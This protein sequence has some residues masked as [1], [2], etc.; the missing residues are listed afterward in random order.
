MI[1]VEQL[2]R[3]KVTE[4]P[5]NMPGGGVR[6][7]L[8]IAVGVLIVA[9]ASVAWV[10]LRHDQRIKA[11]ADA[12]DASISS[13]EKLL[14]Y[15]PGTVSKELDSELALLTGSFRTEYRSL[16]KTTIAPAATKG[17]VTTDASVA[18]SSTVAQGRDRVVLLTFVNVTTRSDELAD[19][20]VSGSRLRLTM[21][22]DGDRWLISKM[23]PV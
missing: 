12:R 15:D 8:T 16:V 21:D 14:S 7:S 13:V 23:E 18:A 2:V 4:R 19:P 5:D 6:L 10:N 1:G 20:R 17:N 11:S 3:G 22:K 9:L